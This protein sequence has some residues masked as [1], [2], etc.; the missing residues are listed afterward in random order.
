MTTTG[1]IKRRE[2]YLLEAREPKADARWERQNFYNTHA[3]AIDAARTYKL[4]F[5]LSDVRL[6]RFKE[7]VTKR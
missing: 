3:D 2:Q 4:V 1:W 5:P 6:V 7:D